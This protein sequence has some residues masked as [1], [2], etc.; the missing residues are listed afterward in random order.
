MGL[1]RPVRRLTIRGG[2]LRGLPVPVRGVS[3]RATGGGVAATA[4]QG[5]R[6]RGTHRRLACCAAGGLAFRFGQRR[7]R[8]GERDY[9]ARYLARVCPCQRFADSL[10]VAAA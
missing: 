8:P 10:A 5:L 7:R 9:A 2:R 4:L 1:L 6:L 3:T